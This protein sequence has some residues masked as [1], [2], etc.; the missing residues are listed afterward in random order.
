MTKIFRAIAKRLFSVFVMVLFLFPCMV[1]AA[2]IRVPADQSTIQAA[3][4]PS[5]AG[6]R[7]VVE[8]KD[9]HMRQGM[10]IIDGKAVT[11]VSKE[12]FSRGN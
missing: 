2:T 4:K 9:S 11:S 7:I 3:I 10:Q 8:R 6:D 1:L 5:R 12:V